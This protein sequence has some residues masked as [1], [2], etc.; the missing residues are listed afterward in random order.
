M[1][2]RLF[3]ALAVLAMASTSA[4]AATVYTLDKIVYANTFTIA[5]FPNDDYT[6]GGPNF[7]GTCYGCGTST[8]VDDGLGN[9]TLTGVS[10]ET[11]ANG[12]QFT[13]TFS[14]T[15]TIGT[16]VTLTKDPGWSCV[17]TVLVSCVSATAGWGG[18]G[19]YTGLGS[20]GAT[21]CLTPAAAPRCAVNVTQVSPSAL[22]VEIRKALSE[23]A[24][25]TFQAYTLHYSV[26]P[27]P[28]AVWLFG[29]ALG[30]MGLVRRKQ[31]A[32]A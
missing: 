22:T 21:A 10:W 14:G 32:A 19:Y 26:V 15:T 3:A 27:V 23:S 8:A 12:Y 7:A 24:G 11:N 9:I 13:N 4:N 30:L 6:L 18:A 20:D 25:A 29:S 5:F 1:K 16:G 2:I 28:A 17:D 31:L